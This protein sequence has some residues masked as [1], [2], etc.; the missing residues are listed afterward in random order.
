MTWRVESEVA[1]GGPFGDALLYR[2]FTLALIWPRSCPEYIEDD[3]IS[4]ELNKCAEQEV[5]P[6]AL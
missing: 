2:E 1:V 5:L 3:V 6:W 4:I